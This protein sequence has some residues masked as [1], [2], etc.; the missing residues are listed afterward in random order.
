[1]RYIFL[2]ILG[3]IIV[4]SSIAWRVYTRYRYSQYVNGIVSKPFV[5]PNCGHRF[6]TKQRI[7]Y[8][9]GENKVLLKC[10]NCGKLDICRIPYDFDGN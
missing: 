6:Y 7:I 8:P 2:I 3:I 10:P 4:V 5:C 9:I 1:M